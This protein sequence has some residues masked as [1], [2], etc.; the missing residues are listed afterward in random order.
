MCMVKCELCGKLFKQI[1]Y[2]HLK[3]SHNITMNEYRNMFPDAI[4]IAD[5]YKNIG[6]KNVMKNPNVKIKHARVVNTTKYKEN[7]R[8][9][10]KIR[11]GKLTKQERSKIYGKCG[12]KNP[13]KQLK[14][15][16]KISEGVKRSYENNDELRKIRS[17]TIGEVGKRNF[18]K[19]AEYNYKNKIWV[20]PEDKEGYKGYVEQVRKLTQK[21]FTKHFYDIKNSK[22]RGPDWHLDHMV[23]ISYGY[24]HDIPVDVIAHYKNLEVIPAKENDSKGYKCSL[25]IEQLYEKIGITTK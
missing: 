13:S 20:R 15:R 6:D 10:N 14:N 25:T 5:E 19:I 18:K 21:N 11:Y 2:R 17:K 7:H 22:L 1:Q 24:N 4:L 12:D 16:K 9:I 3:Y 8:R 23:S